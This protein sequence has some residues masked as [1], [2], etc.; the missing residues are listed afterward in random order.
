VIDR[1]TFLRCLGISGAGM[2]MGLRGRIAHAMPD[3][4]PRRLLV[5]SHCH[6]WPYESWRL[7]PEGT[8]DAT[9]WE[10]DLTSTPESTFSQPLAPLFAHRRRMLAL[11]GLSLLSAELD[12]DGNRHD[13][14]WVH[15]WTGDQADF[16]GSDTR[17]MG[18]SLDQMVAAQIART[19]RLPSLELSVDANRE[20]GRPIAYTPA[21]VRLPVA[22][23]TSLA[24]QRLFGL[25]A[26]T[27]P[28]LLRQR[29]V[30]AFAKSE[31]DALKPRLSTI[32]KD[33]MGAHYEMLDRLGSRISGMAGLSCPDMPD[34]PLG[35]DNYSDRFDVFSELVAS[36]FS[37]DITRVVSLSLGEMPTA[38]FGWDHL[39][40]DIHK[41]IAH[42]LY[43][44]DDKHQAMTDYITMHAEQV[45]RL[46]TLLENTPD[47]DG[48]SV[49]DNTLIVWGSE[50]ANGWHGYQHYCPIIFGGEWHFRTGRYLHWPHKTPGK[51]LVPASIDP[52]GYSSASGLPHQHLLVSAAQAMGLSED[53]IGLS[54]L[55]GQDGDYIDCSGPLPDLI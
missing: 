22:N 41:G 12:V 26:N 7:R 21:G 27:D 14:G 51:L 28:L 39:S 53:I 23:T 8:D 36:A 25:S 17:A 19:D 33:R 1:R 50:L 37:C 47:T 54:H 32:Q 4:T 18:A 13:T 16:S 46:I 35:E 42:G 40:D 34:A 20:G 3:E 45:A 5:I 55:Q 43:D 2:G 10:M 49:M 29:E 44:S 9:A 15:A 24:W 6:G 31:Y 30:L 11:D 38:D 52:S 48:R